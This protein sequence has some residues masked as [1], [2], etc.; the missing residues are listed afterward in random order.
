MT[1]LNVTYTVRGGENGLEV[2][3]M[4]E[5][6]SNTILADEFARYTQ[7]DIYLYWIYF[8]IQNLEKIFANRSSE[9]IVPVI[10]PK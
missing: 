9:E 3:L 5:N 4:V 6:P 2:Y 7:R 8:P 10:S 1:F